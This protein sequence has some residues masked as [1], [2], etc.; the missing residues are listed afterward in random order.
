[1]ERDERVFI[2]GED[3]GPSGGVLKVTD[4]HATSRRRS[5]LDTPLRG[6]IIAA[7]IGSSMMGLRPAPEIQFADFITPLRSRS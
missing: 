7:A 4:G 2:L 1:M 3:I 5:V 6:I